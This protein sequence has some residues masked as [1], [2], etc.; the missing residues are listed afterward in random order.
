MGTTI[1]AQG[2]IKL[3]GKTRALDGLDLVAHSGQVTAV[4][5][6][7]GAGKTTFVRAVATLLAPDG[8]TL[9]V[10]GY[11]VRQDPRSVRR[12]IGLAGQFAAVEPAMT[13]RENLEMVARLFGQGRRAAKRSAAAVLEQLGLVQDGDRLARTYSGGMRRRLDLGASLVGSPRLL[14]LDEPTTGL[15]PRSRNELWE[16][17]RGLVEGGTDVLLTTQYLD[18]ADH[19]ATQ[20]VIIDHGHT[21]ASGTPT[22]LKRRIGGNVVELHVRHEEQLSVVAQ[23]LDRLDQSDAQIDAPTRRVSVR[24]EGGSDQ[25][26]TALRSV[27]ASQVE[28]EDIALRQPNLDEVFLALTGQPTAGEDQDAAEAA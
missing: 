18:E 25:L 4:L 20:I 12:L 22:E 3:Y 14:L 15:D 1:E 19:L 16:A 21:V 26:M 6:P 5:G 28:I 23:L 24:V 7:N 8:G 17:I 10:A 11:D 27:D 13:G 9:R 2:L